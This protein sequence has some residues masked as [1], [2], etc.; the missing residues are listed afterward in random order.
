M[1][2]AGDNRPG[3]VGQELAFAAHVRGLAGAAPPPDVPAARMQVYVDLVF[4]NLE[5]LLGSAFPVAKAVL[6]ESR[7]PALV[8][9]FLASH[10][11]RTPYFPE[12]SQEFL[13]FV[14][15]LPDGAVP[16]FLVEL[17]HYEW[18]ELGLDLADTEL[19]RDVDPAG[20]LLTGVVVRSPL[21]WPLTYAYPVHRIGPG[22][23]PEAPG[24][25][26]TH[27]VVHRDADERVRFMEV[28]DLTQRLLLLLDGVTGHEA[29]Q[30][31]AAEA[32]PAVRPSLR[33]AGPAVL[34][35]LRRAGILLG[36]RLA[37]PGP[38]LVA[39]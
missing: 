39:E 38:A 32:P 15:H 20:D 28:N 31:L 18:V 1:S 34:E 36:T 9:R 8:R 13:E 10:P 26:P 24:A 23:E 17:C 7:W 6:G 21:A 2:S 4:R 35:R 22:R 29:L 19:P 11:S 14:G 33:T 25:Q 3:F 12:V 16:G 27:L 5:T 30:R 37:P